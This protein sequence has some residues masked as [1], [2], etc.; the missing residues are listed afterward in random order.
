MT[1]QQ[2]IKW[3][4]SESAIRTVLMEVNV[5]VGGVETVRYLSNKGYVTGA[6]DAPA[7]T[8]YS[9]AIVGG[10]KFTET[11][12]IDGS[13]SLSYGDIELSN[14][15]GDRDSWLDDVWTNRS[16]QV[17]IGDV[18]WPRSEF[19]KVFDGIVVSID[20]RKRDRINLKLSDK[21]QRL[22]TPISETKLIDLVPTT[23]STN[24]DKLI[25]LCF[26]E[27]HNVEPLLVDASQ[28]EYQVHNGPI[29]DIIEVRDNGV[30]V[31]VTKF[32]STGKFRLTA[33]PVGTIT[34]S[35]QGDKPAAG[36][37]NNAATIVKR[38][39][40]S[41]GNA[42][43]RLTDADIDLTNIAAFA[44]ANTAPVGIYLKD[45]ANVI[46]VCNNLVKS[47]GARVAMSRTG[48]L[49]IVKLDLPQASAGTA[50]NSSMMVDK[51]LQVNAVH[52]VKAGVQLGYC[53]NWTVQNSLQTGL[54]E[55]HIKLYSEEWLTVTKTDDA[56]ASTYMLHTEPTME[57]TMLLTEADANAEATRRLDMWKVARK[58]IKYEGFGDL[59]FERL[60]N[61][62]TITHERFGL[63]N[64]KTGQV[65]SLVTDWL[66]PHTEV[67]VLL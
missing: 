23:V 8:V 53:K 54:P 29:E 17:Y 65:V 41:Y 33:S 38:I 50:I 24:K 4:K 3:L 51:S 59:M 12:S 10:V 9:P 52:D 62:Q 18:T 67:E 14:T 61:P 49:Y 15:T 26:G 46:D 25:P 27:C 43:Q 39:V 40:T 1:E 2:L 58:S 16:V 47:L 31:A 11:L 30:P 64:G 28:H 20:S 36:Y 56:V 44:A 5:R 57:E 32:L 48:L 55:E 63:Q 21:M 22:N 34:C 45:R 42:S 7:N 37:S 13:P 19:Y 60:G 6:S 66:D 35:V